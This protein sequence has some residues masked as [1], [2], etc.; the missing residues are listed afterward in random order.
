M[1]TEGR[2]LVATLGLVTPHARKSEKEKNHHDS[3][4]TEKKEKTEQR[5]TFCPRYV[6]VHFDAS[7]FHH[8]FAEIIRFPEKPL[9]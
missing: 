2:L 8:D 4:H 3:R 9:G 6:S 5:R 1:T 7:T